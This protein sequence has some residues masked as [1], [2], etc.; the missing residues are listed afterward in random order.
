MN[1]ITKLIAST[2]IHAVNDSSARR[3]LKQTTEEPANQEEATEAL[4]VED[5][6]GLPLP[7]DYTS[8]S[9]ESS[10][11]RRVIEATS[12]SSLPIL[13]EFFSIEL[14]TVGWQSCPIDGQPGSA[15]HLHLYARHWQGIGHPGRSGA[16]PRSGLAHSQ[17]CHADDPPISANG[18]RSHWQAGAGANST[19]VFVATAQLF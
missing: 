4:T 15:T 17:C 10:Q 16:G 13:V 2:C 11:F 8:Y 18:G 12:L 9:S 3:S 7:S 5:K 6:D 1:N 19:Q 14:S